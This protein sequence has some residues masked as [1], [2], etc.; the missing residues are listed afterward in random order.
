MSETRNCPKCGGECW[1][2][3]VDVE[4]GVIHG[5]W[6]C[7]DCGWSE[8]PYYDSSEGPPPY[9]KSNPGLTCNPQGGVFKKIPGQET[10]GGADERGT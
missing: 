10:G 7:S 6:G 4:V 8:D 2:E 5:P 9:E 1:R 3:S